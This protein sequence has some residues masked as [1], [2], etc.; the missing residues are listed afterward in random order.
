VSRVLHLITSL[1]QGGAERQLTYLC[2]GLAR[3]GW[4][5][6]VGFLEAD[7][8]HDDANLGRLRASGVPTHH[9]ENAGAYDP[10]NPLRFARLIR[11]LR[12]HIVQTWIPMV[13][14][15]GGLAARW[16]R[17]PWVMSERNTP[18]FYAFGWKFTLRRWLVAGAAAVVSNSLPADRYWAQRLPARVRRRVVRNALPLEEI[19]AAAARPEDDFGIGADRPVV[20]FA[21]RLNE[22]KNI[23]VLLPALE[24]VTHRT[25]AVS[26]ICGRGELAGWVDEFVR[27]R[28]LGDRIR[29]VG[30][31]R[32]LWPWM[33][34]AAVLVSVSRYEGMPNTAMEAAALGCPLV[35]SAIPH[36]ADLFDEDSAVFADADDPDAIADAVVSVLRDRAGARSRAERAEKLADAWSIDRAAALHAELYDELLAGTPA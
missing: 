23:R 22:Q 32:A 18:D 36:H 24:R 30:F 3:L 7:L 14:V 1:A 25:D 27:S 28:D 12:P 8:L 19:R 31:V 29:P 6:H 17:T 10:L 20:L 21:G 16:T 5:V 4:D 35:L 15:T 11:R 26:L 9:V 33:K 13:D 2:G 34:R